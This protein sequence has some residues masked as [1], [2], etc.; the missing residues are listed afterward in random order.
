MGTERTTRRGGASSA[1]P[2]ERAGG[3]IAP[4]ALRR[5]RAGALVI[6]LVA[7]VALV[8]GI[9][10]GA[11]AGGGSAG[12][13][14]ADTGSPAEVEPIELP[15]GGT[16]LLPDY[17]LVGFYG[18]PQDVELGALGIGTP[19]EAAAQLDKQAAAYKGNRPLQPFQELLATVANADPGTDG[20]YRTQ[21]PRSVIEDY[22]DQARKDKHLLVLDI[23]P[24]LA[25]FSDEVKRLDRYL[26][27]PDVGL[28]LDPEWHVQP[29][30][31]PGQVIG[32]MEASEVN[33]IARGLSRVVTENGLPQKLLIVHRFTED[34][35]AGAEKLRSYPG[36]ALVLN[37][38]GF[39][40]PPEK[41]VKYKDLHAPKRSDLFSGFKLFYSEDTDLMS[42]RD[43][44][45]LKP[46]PN[47]IVYE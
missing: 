24:G 8:A 26:R 9:S 16:V 37:V 20:K 36:V 33:R 11:G 15:R 6:A 42:P 41:I 45:K 17:R 28:A 43:V 46:T 1:R 12:A 14:A 30:E 47:L 13:G 31:V 32:S 27:E 23:Q 35:I 34:M 25:D 7:L 18:A 5:R 38:D 21:Q 39:G 29:G 10:A 19:A 44:L 2:R 40:A 3:A 4:K 22:L